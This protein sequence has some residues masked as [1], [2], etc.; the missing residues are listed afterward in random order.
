MS[1][2]SGINKSFLN[3]KLAFVSEGYRVKETKRGYELVKS[4]TMILL[5]KM[6]LT[7]N[8]M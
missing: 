2:E 5:Q 6:A 3:Q 7:L 8:S 4:S 1:V